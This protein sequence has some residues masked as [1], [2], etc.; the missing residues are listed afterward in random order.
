MSYNTLE[1]LRF[2]VF[3]TLE[4]FENYYKLC[5]ESNFFCFYIFCN[6]SENIGLV[7]LNKFYMPRYLGFGYEMEEFQIDMMMFN[8]MNVLHWH[9]IDQES[10][11]F[12]VPTVPE[13]SSYGQIRGTYSPQ[14]IR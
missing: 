2:P 4:Q 3:Y 9:I 13:L 8:K 6:D 11:P 10:F 7:S 12:E 5:L 14:D 1:E